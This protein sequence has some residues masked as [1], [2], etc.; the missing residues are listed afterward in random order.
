MKQFPFVRLK[1]VLSQRSSYKG[2]LV[3]R[4]IKFR[5]SRFWLANRIAQALVDGPWIEE[6]A[7]YRMIA[8]KW[9]ARL[10]LLCSTA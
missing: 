7:R 3:L 1:L 2:M 9:T 4:Q 8:A 5:R 6:P 10:M